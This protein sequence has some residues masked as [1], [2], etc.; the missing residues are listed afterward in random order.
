MGPDFLD[1]QRVI[2]KSTC[3]VS[4]LLLATKDEEIAALK[5]HLGMQRNK[6]QAGIYLLYVQ[7][8]FTHIVQL[9]HEMDQEFLDRQ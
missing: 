8:V 1:I 3:R 6:N 4:E 9:L 2:L 7:E 5:K